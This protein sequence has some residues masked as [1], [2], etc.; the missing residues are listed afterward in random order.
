[1]KQQV[2][3]VRDIKANCVPFMPMYVT[4]VG[5]AI[6]DFGDQCRNKETLIGK[7]PEDYELY[8]HGEWDDVEATYTPLP[9]PV[10]LA[11]GS[12]YAQA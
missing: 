7:H 4:H 9:R 6:R 8:Q 3:Y 10:Q 11:C 2:L 12:N 1:M 5:M